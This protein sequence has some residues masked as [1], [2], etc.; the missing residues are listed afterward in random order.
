[1]R[2]AAAKHTRS[3][4]GSFLKGGGTPALPKVIHAW[5]EPRPPGDVYTLGGN[6]PPQTYA[7]RLRSFLTAC[8]ARHEIERAP[9]PLHEVAVSEQRRGN[10][11]AA[12]SMHGVIEQM[13]VRAR[14]L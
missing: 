13:G 5:L 7:R 8:G 4:R 12:K 1:M 9:H 14:R 6:A 2:D 10:C 11:A 3:S